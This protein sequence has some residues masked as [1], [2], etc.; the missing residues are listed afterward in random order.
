MS[1]NILI[2]DT[3]Q[4]GLVINELEVLEGLH[5]VPLL[6]LVEENGHVLLVIQNPH[7]K[8]FRF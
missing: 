1:Q 7:R 5:A 2:P 4:V 6:L 8:Y 3:E